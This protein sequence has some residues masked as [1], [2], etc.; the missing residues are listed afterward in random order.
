MAFEVHIEQKHVGTIAFGEREAFFGRRGL[1]HGPSVRSEGDSGER[2][3]P[4]IVVSD[5]NAR[6]LAMSNFVHA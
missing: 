3:D 2:S 1:D 5:Q 6:L 4:G